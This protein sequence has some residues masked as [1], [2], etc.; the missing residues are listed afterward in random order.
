MCPA[1]SRRTRWQETCTH[2]E[3]RT[4]SCPCS[5]GGTGWFA[6]KMHKKGPSNPEGRHPLDVLL[7][8]SSIG[9]EALLR[10]SGWRE[11]NSKH[12]LEERSLQ[13]LPDI[14][15]Y[16]ADNWDPLLS[17]QH[18]Q[19]WNTKEMILLGTPS[20]ISKKG[21]FSTSSSASWSYMDHPIREHTEGVTASN[22]WPYFSP[23]K[24]SASFINFYMQA[25]LSFTDVLEGTI[26][27]STSNKE[28]F[29]HI[30]GKSI[31]LQH[32][33]T[34]YRL[35]GINKGELNIILLLA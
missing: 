20:E 7:A 31:R 24:R 8:C 21:M 25:R 16:V 5:A 9:L 2:T 17:A 1:F 4:P 14:A 18:T 29:Y 33:L 28:L 6:R 19:S 35:Q 15:W 13:I 27:T 30:A 23:E 32:I 34:V 12:Y 11:H 10:S 22:F 3:L 26:Y